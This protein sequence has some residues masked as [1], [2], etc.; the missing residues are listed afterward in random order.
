MKFGVS[1]KGMDETTRVLTQLPGLFAR[2]RRS[3][4]SSA[5]WMVRGE[6]RDWVEGGGGGTWPKVHPLTMK[7]R[8]KRGIKAGP[9]VFTR[10]R[11]GWSDEPLVWLGKFARYRLNPE[12]TLAEIDMGRSAKG[13]PGAIDPLL[14]AVARRSEQ[15]ETIHV[16]DAMRR[17]LAAG[18]QRGL[19]RKARRGAKAGKDCFPLRK[20]TGTLRVPRRPIFGPVSRRVE[21]KVFPWFREKFYA[22]L[23]RY[24]T[25]AAKK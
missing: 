24:R 7:F 20:S 4:L 21:P 14:Q 16:S 15:G 9:R 10:R 2:A 23:E 5:A 22:A 6:I 19:S 11:S 13:R 25:G 8:K 18:T 3:A 17:M 1:L 12:A